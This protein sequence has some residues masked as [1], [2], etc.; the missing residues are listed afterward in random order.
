MSK[1]RARLREE[2]ER[3]A[4]LAAATR[5][6]E[7]QKAAQRERRRQV[8]LG[9]V[10]RPAPAPSGTLAARRRRDIG[11][12]LT[13]VFALNLLVFLASDGW[14]L[15]TVVLLLSVLLTPVATLLISQK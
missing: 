5:A 2:R 11:L 8:L 7:A 6:A 13:A 1:E 4:T 12:V 9:W 10:P 3:Q 15:R 14:A